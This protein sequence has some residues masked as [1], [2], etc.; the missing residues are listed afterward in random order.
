MLKEVKIEVTERCER[1]CIHCSSNAINKNYVSMSPSVV[2][3]IIREAKELGAKSV[4]FTGGEATLYPYLDQ[5]VHYATTQGLDSKLYTMAT[6]NDATIKQI[7]K[8]T[9]YGLKEM[10]YSTT[11]RL[12][13]DGVVSLERLQEF[14][15][16]LLRETDITLGVH[17]AVTKKTDSDIE[18][19]LELFFSLPEDRTSKF[20]LLRFVPH[21]RG[22]KTLLLSHEELL[23]LKNDIDVWRRKYCSDKIRLGSPWNLLGIQHTPCTAADKTM[24]V[25]F[26]GNVYPCDA[27]KYFDYLGSGGN[28]YESSLGDIFTSPYFEAIRKYKMEAADECV[29]CP[30]F[31]CCKGGCLGQKMIAFVDTTHMTFKEYGDQALRTMKDFGSNKIKRMNGELGIIGELGE[32]FDSFKKLK[33]HEL[34]VENKEKILKNLAIEAGDIMWYIAASLS[35]SYGVSFEEIGESLFGYK[36]KVPPTRTPIEEEDVEKCVKRKDPECLFT[37]QSKYYLLSSLDHFSTDYDFDTYWKDLVA[38]AC[39]LL[40][41]QDRKEVVRLSASFMVVLTAILN[42]E[43]GISIEEAARLNIEKLKSRYEQGFSTNVSNARIDLLTEYKTSEVK[44][45]RPYQKHI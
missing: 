22:D 45:E 1:M 27:M 31:A 37:P 2:K 35:N 10:I 25:G 14:F 44:T 8:L 26:D 24:I 11:W 6:P 42:H 32:F 17:H 21:G 38:N 16:K 43:V 36:R 5:V 28:I 33:T 7:K 18:D 41:A 23:S 20:S 30:Q 40:Y 13:R 9:F 34:T 4:V 3:R 19:A 12:T 15:P 29:K 39:K